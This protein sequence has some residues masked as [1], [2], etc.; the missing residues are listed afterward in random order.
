M[1]VTFQFFFFWN[2]NFVSVVPVYKDP[3]FACAT[4]VRRVVTLYYLC[5][6]FDCKCKYD[7][8]PWQAWLW[9]TILLKNDKMH[10]RMTIVT[11][12]AYLT[13][14]TSLKDIEVT[15]VKCI[16]SCTTSRGT[17]WSCN[18]YSEPRSQSLGSHDPGVVKACDTTQWSPALSIVTSTIHERPLLTTLK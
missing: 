4:H 14:R 3:N 8:H 18:P 9:Q 7:Q 1:N 12:T 15:N 11:L 5:R 16:H 13:F 17:G 10:Q 6:L 2:W